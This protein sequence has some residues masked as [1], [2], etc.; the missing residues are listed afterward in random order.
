MKIFIITFHWATNYGAVLQTYATQEFLEKLGHEVLVIDYVPKNY[1]VKFFNCFITR[2]LSN[3]RLNIIEYRKEKLLKRFRKKY[4]KLTK[5]YNSVKELKTEN[6]GAYTYICGSDQIWNPY[7]TMNGENGITLPYF[8]N[9]VP[10][11]SKKIAYAVSFG[12]EKISNEMKATIQN[13]IKSFYNISVRE[14][15]GVKIINDCGVDCQ[16]VCDPVFL[17]NKTFYEQ[18]ISL[19]PHYDN[20]VFSYILHNDKNAI[21]IVDNIISN[22][23]FSK[24][25]CNEYCKLSEWLEYI[26][27]SDL[28]I[29]NSFHATALAII[30]HTPFISVLIEGSGMNDRIITLLSQLGLKNRIVTENNEQKIKE[31]L[32][33]EI[34]WQQV[35]LK[36]NKMRS[37]GQKFLKDCLGEL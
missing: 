8:L 25:N 29:T 1:R 4:L 9:F 31:V 30:F 32:N 17:H 5:R 28:V 10:K 18:L 3:I 2:K 36:V 34:D 7:F 12:V 6:W 26:H 13:E 20:S 23:G 11:T 19:T 16:V 21:S 15:S 33:N 14:N 35:D 37:I 27:Y 22:Y 24:I